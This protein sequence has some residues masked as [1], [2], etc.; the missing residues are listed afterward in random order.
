MKNIILAISILAAMA[1]A[2]KYTHNFDGKWYDCTES[3][4]NDYGDTLKTIVYGF[5]DD[6]SNSVTTYKYNKKHQK[7]SW[8]SDGEYG[9]LTYNKFGKISQEVGRSYWGKWYNYTHTYSYDEDGNLIKFHTIH[10]DGYSYTT[11][12][13]NSISGRLLKSEDSNGTLCEYYPNGSL[14]RRKGS[15]DHRSFDRTYPQSEYDHLGRVVKSGEWGF[16][17]K[18]FTKGNHHYKCYDN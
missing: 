8:Y 5:Y 15:I 6:G 17:Y 12:Y 4:L 9:K 3:V 18:Y 2:T 11:W 7:I 14:K 1:C 13:T 10:S 16:K